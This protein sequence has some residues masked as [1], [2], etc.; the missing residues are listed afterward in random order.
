M[1]HRSCL[2]L[3]SALWGIGSSFACSRGD[4]EPC[5]DKAPG[6]P[7]TLCAPGDSDCV[8]LMVAKVCAANGFCGGRGDTGSPNMDRNDD[9]SWLID[10]GGG[11]CLSWTGVEDAPSGGLWLGAGGGLFRVDATDPETAFRIDRR[12][13]EAAS[14]VAMRRVREDVFVVFGAPEVVRFGPD[15]RRTSL[16][17]GSTPIAVSDNGCI[18]VRRDDELVVRA[19]GEDSA[20]TVALPR[21]VSG[22]RLGVEAAVGL[23]DSLLVRTYRG[24][25]GFGALYDVACPNLRVTEIA[26]E[27]PIVNLSAFVRDEANRLWAIDRER[28]VRPSKSR[29]VRSEDSGRT[30]SAVPVP[31]DW[32][33]SSFAIRGD[34]VV[35]APPKLHAVL[36]STDGGANWTL[37]PVDTFTSVAG[38]ETMSVHISER[39]IVTIGANCNYLVHRRLPLDRHSGS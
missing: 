9:H 4:Y 27:S 2:L 3:L 13:I 8:E 30:W 5:A 16:G 15:G 11:F 1:R 38:F 6:D 35:V 14:V 22:F 25:D 20:R 17:P 21:P 37:E 10:S 29:L 33:S 31:K 34:W 19:P 24:R 32:Q 36:V 28:G 39:G 23:A 12:A 26:T 7:C 18:G